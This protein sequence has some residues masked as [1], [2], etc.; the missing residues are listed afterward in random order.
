MLSTAP[1][2]EAHILSSFGGIFM[3]WRLM[4]APDNELK[5]PKSKRRRCNV[6]L[7]CLKAFFIKNFLPLGFLV[8]IIWMIVW[9]WPGK[10]V[11]SWR[12]CLLAVCFL[13]ALVFSP[14]NTDHNLPSPP[15]AKP[16]LLLNMHTTH[17]QLFSAPR[18]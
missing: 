14:P 15:P 17:Q 13:E 8:S 9:P 2:R 7:P 18:K 5:E 3:V 12:V 6:S 10:K 4:Q 11:A 16:L 1:A